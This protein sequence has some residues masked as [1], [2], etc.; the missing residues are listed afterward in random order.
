MSTAESF[1]KREGPLRTFRNSH[2]LFALIVPAL[3]IGFWKSY[4]G[5]LGD[6]PDKVTTTI[7]VHS[8]TMIV[9]IFMLV[10]QA[11]F[12]RSKQFALH[13][14]VGRSSYVVAPVIV[15]IGLVAMREFV[16]R[17]PG[18]VSY[19][20]ARDLNLGFG[21]LL[22]FAVTW[23]LAVVYRKQPER[24]IRFMI[25]TAFSLAT[26]IVFRILISWVPGF[27]TAQAAVHGNFLVLGVLLGALIANDWRLGLRRSPFLVVTVMIALMYVSHLAIVRT[28]IWLAYCE[29]FRSLPTWILF[30]GNVP[31]LDLTQLSVRSG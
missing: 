26:A 11:W 6:L 23:S 13:R 24:H 21:Q 14:L 18:A 20:Q 17:E 4:F 3:L 22:A 16:G 31:N 8:L 27:G 25:S 1:P 5:T 2:L 12:I 7:H 30:T 29:W 9:W 10:A 15:W 28:D 19:D